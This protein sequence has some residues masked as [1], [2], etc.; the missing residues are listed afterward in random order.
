MATA[1][2]ILL[3][4][5]KQFQTDVGSRHNH[6]H[7]YFF[8]LKCTATHFSNIHVHVCRCRCTCTCTCTCTCI[9]VQSIDAVFIVVRSESDHPHSRRGSTE[10]KKSSNLRSALPNT[11]NDWSDRTPSFRWRRLCSMLLY[12]TF[13]P[14]ANKRLDI[15]HM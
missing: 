13:I 14:Y 6:A 9:I 11:T 7:C 4:L 1:F 10:L 15:I 8:A 12:G 3:G 2:I 5:L